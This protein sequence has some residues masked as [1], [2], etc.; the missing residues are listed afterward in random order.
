MWK[1]KK[2]EWMIFWG[3]RCWHKWKRTEGLKEN[4]DE[5]D[6]NRGKESVGFRLVNTEDERDA[7]GI[8]ESW[9]EN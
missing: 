1:K 3:N 2:K 9:R 4:E 5:R 6:K 8:W 7:W